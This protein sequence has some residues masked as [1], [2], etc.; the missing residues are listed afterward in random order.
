M[1][2]IIKKLLHLND[3]ELLAITE[4]IDLELERRQDREEEIP[5]SARRRAVSR[6]KSYRRTTG[7]TAPPVRATGLK[8]IKKRRRAA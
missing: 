6:D 7:S 1:N 5:E 2:A 8:D 3:D 4:A